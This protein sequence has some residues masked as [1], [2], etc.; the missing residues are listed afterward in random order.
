MKSKQIYETKVRYEEEGGYY[1]TK[2][3]ACNNCS[4]WTEKQKANNACTLCRNERG[5]LI[6]TGKYIP[7]TKK[8]IEEKILIG[9]YN[10]TNESGFSGLPGGYRENCCRDIDTGFEDI[11]DDGY[12]WSS[13]ENKVYGYGSTENGTMGPWY[14]Y[15]YYLNDYL[16]VGSYGKDYAYSEKGKGY[17]VRCLRD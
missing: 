15:L 7:K 5:K 2:W 11:G 6:K 13:S 12:W 4:Y 14:C 9:G 3:V 16:N 10:G 8:K 17:S 1:E